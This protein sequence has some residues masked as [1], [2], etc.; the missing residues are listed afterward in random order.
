MNSSADLDHIAD[1]LA[2]EHWVLL[3]D[4][5]EPELQHELLAIAR[6]RLASGALRPARIGR[7]DGLRHDP[8]VRGDAIQWLEPTDPAPCVLELLHLLD[9]L[10]VALNERLYL[11][12][13]ETEAHF[14][15]Y[16]PGAGYQRHLDRFR[17]D[18][19]R[20]ISA[21]IHLGEPWLPAHAGELRMHLHGADGEFEI[22]LPPWPGQLVLFASGEVEH[23]VLPTR[24]D[25]Y[26][27]AG[28]MRRRG[29]R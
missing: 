12:L 22:D 11:N 26:S 19:A 4:W 7:V 24:R 16:P 15:H 13:V 2:A 5:I 27:I 25:R 28:W 29:S 23:S 9:A 8:G 17:S 6:Q 20:T 3:R 21:V 10:R 1:A 14:A 18:E